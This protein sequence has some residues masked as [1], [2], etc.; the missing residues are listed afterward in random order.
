MT[1][2]FKGDSQT[3]VK[4][5]ESEEVTRQ[6][7]AVANPGFPTWGGGNPTDGVSTHFLANFF[8]KTTWKL[9]HDERQRHS[10][11][12]CEH[13]YLFYYH[14]PNEPWHYIRGPCILMRWSNGLHF[15]GH[16]SVWPWH[17]PRILL[18]MAFCIIMSKY[19]SD[20][21]IKM[22]AIWQRLLLDPPM[23]RGHFLCVRFWRT[24]SSLEV[25]SRVNYYNKCHKSDENP[26]S[27]KSRFTGV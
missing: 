19:Q 18:L 17:W 11:P 15:G 5:F 16:C 24:W 27:F 12:R 6:L 3:P 23:K 26:V 25:A 21:L 14:I 7:K 2:K 20:T 13:G 1:G 10:G 8:S 22:R 4:T 9:S